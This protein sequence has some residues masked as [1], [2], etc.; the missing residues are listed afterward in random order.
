VHRKGLIAAGGILLTTLTALL[1]AN[2][3]LASVLA[4][5]FAAGTA[6]GVWGVA[7]AQQPAYVAEHRAADRADLQ[8]QVKPDPKG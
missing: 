7:N 1:P 3:T 8:A 4:G 2:S 6:A 5:V